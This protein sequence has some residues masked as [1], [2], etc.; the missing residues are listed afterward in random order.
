VPNTEEIKLA[1]RA[2]A[3]MPFDIFAQKNPIVNT[4][5]KYLDIMF[6]VGGYFKALSKI[7]DQGYG[8]QPIE[9]SDDKTEE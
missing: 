1:A 6:S 3:S 4:E 9:F 2:F 7:I 8:T 5:T